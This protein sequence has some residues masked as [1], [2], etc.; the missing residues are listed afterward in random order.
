MGLVD[1]QHIGSSQNRDRTHVLC[2]GRQILNHWTT[3]EAPSFLICLSLCV[4]ICLTMV[5][6]VVFV[7]S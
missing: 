2:I 3:I 6:G 5:R 4:S 1:P 7:T